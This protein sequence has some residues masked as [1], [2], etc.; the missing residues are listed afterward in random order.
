MLLNTLKVCCFC[1]QVQLQTYEKVDSLGEPKRTVHIKRQITHI[2]EINSIYNSPYKILIQWK[3]IF[4][5]Y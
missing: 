1:P 2:P 3:H 5:P 4:F